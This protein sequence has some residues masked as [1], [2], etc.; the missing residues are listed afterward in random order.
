[1][2]Y[3]SWK[4]DKKCY[5]NNSLTSQIAGGVTAK[6]FFFFEGGGGWVREM[7]LIQRS[8]SCTSFERS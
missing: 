2:Q 4:W 3:V 5:F 7:F 8:Y 1:M 6:V